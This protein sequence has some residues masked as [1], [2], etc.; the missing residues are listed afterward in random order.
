MPEGVTQQ[1]IDDNYIKCYDKEFQVT[2]AKG[3]NKNLAYTI[4]DNSS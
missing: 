1:Q 4:F 3:V 2:N